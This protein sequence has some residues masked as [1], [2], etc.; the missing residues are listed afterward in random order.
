VERALVTRTPVVLG[1]GF[2]V[3]LAL[4]GAGCFAPPD[5][6]GRKDGCF[7]ACPAVEMCE[8]GRCRNRITEFNVQEVVGF[9]SDWPMDLVSGAD[10]NLWFTMPRARKIG[11]MTTSGTVTKFAAPGMDELDHGAS[12]LAADS[13]GGVW[14][15]E[16]QLYRIVRMTTEGEVAELLTVAEADLPYDLVVGRDGHIWFVA[17]SGIVRIND[18]RSLTRF[19]LPEPAS[20][21]LSAAPDGSFWFAVSATRLGHLVP[22]TGVVEYYDLG[23]EGLLEGLAVGPDGSVWF[24]HSLTTGGGTIGR[25]RPDE[26]PV[27]FGN[28]SETWPARIAPDGDGNIW[29]SDLALA[30]STSIGRLTP[31]GEITRFPIL[32]IRSPGEILVG[33]DGNLWFTADGTVARLVPP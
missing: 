14:F 7:P 30:D 3:G 32:S 5:R 18:D 17:S 25:L 22:I 12:M 29:F 27:L 21:P 23:S 15:P 11:R 13:V 16:P 1:L 20:S 2:R 26:A 4:M 33:P 6:A 24:S 9:S 8:D 31:E 19:P 10:G 28:P